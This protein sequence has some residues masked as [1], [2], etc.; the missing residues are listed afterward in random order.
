MQF[1]ERTTHDLDRIAFLCTSDHDLCIAENNHKSLIKLFS[2]Y[3]ELF[4]YPIGWF[5]FNQCLAYTNTKVDEQLM[6]SLEVGTHSTSP[7]V[8]QELMLPTTIVIPDKILQ[9][10]DKDLD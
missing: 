4:S 9:Y 10:I 8:V 6:S 7:Q 2:D 5:N 3:Y 1:A